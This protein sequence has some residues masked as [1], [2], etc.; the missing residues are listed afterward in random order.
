MADGLRPMS[1]SDVLGR[2]LRLYQGAAALRIAGATALLTLPIQVLIT[3]ALAQLELADVAATGT[4]PESGDLDRFLAVSIATAIVSFPGF[5]LATTVGVRIAAGEAVAEPPSL[6]TAVVFATDRLLPLLGLSTA[7][8]LIVLGGT[9]VY[10]VPG[11]FAFLVLMLSFPILMVE[12]CGVLRSLVRSTEL[13]RADARLAVGTVALGL[14]VSLGATLVMALVLSAVDVGVDDATFVVVQP[15][16]NVLFAAATAPFTAGMIFWLY[17][18]ARSR[19]EHLTSRLLA[20]ELAFG[21]VPGIGP[22]AEP[23]RPDVVHRHP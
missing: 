23:Y 18:A 7:F 19:A 8:G 14:V 22:H 15:A 12:R 3:V 16:L 11:L 4:L 6:G 2:A 20:D 5:V 13:V 21:A 9:V 17:L 10:V 1:A